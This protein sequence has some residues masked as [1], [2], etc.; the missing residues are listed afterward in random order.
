[1]PVKS[2]RTEQGSW[3]RLLAPCSGPA[4]PSLRNSWQTRSFAAP[5]RRCRRNLPVRRSRLISTASRPGTAVAAGVQEKSHCI[6]Y[7][8][9]GPTSTPR[10]SRFLGV[11]SISPSGSVWRAPWAGHQ[12]HHLRPG[13]WAGFSERR[14]GSPSSLCG[15]TLLPGCTLAVL[16]SDSEHAP[17]RPWAVPAVRLERSPPRGKAGELVSPSTGRVGRPKQIRCAIGDSAS[18]PRSR[19]ASTTGPWD[20]CCPPPE[21]AELLRPDISESLRL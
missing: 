21:G 3:S 2:I 11:P 18:P 9:A 16:D 7:C 6:G 17:G 5:A 8:P 19:A 15:A 1:M 10:Q 20:R 12:A 4:P 13:A 14:A